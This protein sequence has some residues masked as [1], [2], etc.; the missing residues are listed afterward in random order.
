MNRKLGMISSVVTLAAVLVFALAMLLGSNF[1]SYFS[2]LFIAFGFAPMIGAFLSMSSRHRTGMGYTAAL[3]AA[4]YAVLIMLVYFA[5]LTTVRL[6]PL[7]PEAAAILNYQKFGLFF[8]YDLLGYG[9][10]ALS[11]FFIAFTVNVKTRAD[12]ALKILLL[13]HGV[14]FIMCL[15]MPILGVFSP[16]NAPGPVGGVDIGVLILEFW[17]AYFTPVCILSFLHFRKSQQT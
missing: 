7:S 3:F 13:I 14:F 10:M 2:C 9:F 16:E 1:L 6:S 11:T 12:K 5:Q 4:V 15:I 8:S 17:C